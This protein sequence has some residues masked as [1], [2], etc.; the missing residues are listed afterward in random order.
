MGRRD[1]WRSGP[2]GAPTDKERMVQHCNT[3]IYL[4]SMLG[5][6]A[7]DQPEGWQLL[8]SKLPHE[9]FCYG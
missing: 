7:S 1:R 8:I 5:D 3:I 4:A 6:P 2:P 9:K